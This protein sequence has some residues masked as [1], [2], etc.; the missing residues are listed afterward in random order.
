MKSMTGMASAQGESDG[1]IWTADIKSVNGRGLDLKLRIPDT[2]ERLSKPLREYLQTHVTRGSIFLN[3]KANYAEDIA[4]GFQVDPQKID[5]MLKALAEID[6]AALEAGVSLAPSKASDLLNFVAFSGDK[7]ESENTDF[8][9]TLKYLTDMIDEFIASRSTEGEQIAAV[10][11][12]QLEEVR[13]LLGKI[14]AC[15]PVRKQRQ[16]SA[17]QNG[18]QTLLK[19]V[20]DL[21]EQRLLQELALMAIKSDVSEEID[22]LKVHLETAKDLLNSDKPVGRKFDFLM[23][24]F[25]REANTLC[26]KSQDSALTSYGLDLKVVI[27][28]M[29]EQVQNV[30]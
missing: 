12:Q 26:S 3:L 29:R 6:G 27:D 28:Q 19:S 7:R 25:N 4:L 21:D 5:D 30:E 10:L 2:L 1:L 8:V 18:L 23:Q 14:E 11:S 13:R 17:I 20:D 15:L 22:R 16:E 24:E 9:Q